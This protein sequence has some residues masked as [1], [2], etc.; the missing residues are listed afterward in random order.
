MSKE[1][2]ANAQKQLLAVLTQEEEYIKNTISANMIDDFKTNFL[3]LAQNTYL[4]TN[5][6]PK[7]ILNTALQATL[8][9]LNINPIYK[10]MYI[11]P[12]NVKGKGMMPSIVP[13]KQGHVQIAF[14]SGFFLEIQT[15]FNLDGKILSEKELSRELQQQINTTNPEWVDEHV[16]GWDIV[17]TDISHEDVK[18]PTQSKFI[19]YQYAIDATKGQIEMPQF[20]LQNYVHK[21]VR[22]AMGDMFIPRHRRKLVL[23][24]IDQMTYE[25]EHI[26]TIDISEPIDP[27]ANDVV[28]RSV[29]NNTAEDKIDTETLVREIK[30]YYISCP[31][32]KKDKIAKLMSNHKTWK[33]YTK[34]NLLSL[35]AEM[36][37][38]AN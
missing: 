25:A 10:E 30:Q 31:I 34:D 19:E 16:L 26:T 33:S 24:R 14:D 22:R 29:E 27:L 9:G 37:N 3:D 21:A 5:V 8:L 36:K 20:K 32:E 13:T 6:A 18:V 12:F 4:M 28:E 38:V 1:L 2:Q 23:E 15:V 17:L 35:L 11:L 7:E